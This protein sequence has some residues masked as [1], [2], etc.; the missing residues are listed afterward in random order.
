MEL[1]NPIIYGTTENLWQIKFVSDSI[2]IVDKQ[3]TEFQHSSQQEMELG[4][5][6]LIKKR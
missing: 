5:L 6:R 1:K 4:G 3:I 2:M